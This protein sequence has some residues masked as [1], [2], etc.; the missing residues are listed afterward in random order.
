MALTASKLHGVIVAIVTPFTPKDEVDVPGLKKLVDYIVE[1][2]VHGIMTTG[3]NGEFPHLFHDERK[4][5]LEVIN[6][7]C[8]SKVP[9][10]ACVSACGTK[11]V[12][13]L[14]K[15]AKNVG[16]D[17]VILTPPYYFDLPPS[18]ILGHYSDLAKSVD[19]PIV[20]YNNPTYTRHNIT[21]SLAVSL[22]KI[23]G[24]VG[25]KQ[26]NANLS[27]AVEILRLV[28]KKISVLTG[29]DSQLFAAL[30]I[31]A[32][33]VFSTAACVYPKQMVDLYEA[34][35]SGK[36]AE[37]RKLHEKLQIVN[38]FFEYE[39]GYVTPCKEALTM[40]GLPAGPVR[41]P[42][43]PLTQ[44]ERAELKGALKAI[45]LKPN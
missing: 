23:D 32:R 24:V 33:G 21:P 43:P 3:G 45:G 29:I 4:K 6:D 16:A 41:K 22:S 44:Q 7:R 42:M 13:S 36:L 35:R 34:Y 30:C 10:I 25:L 38:K 15:H 19:I 27:E 37:A 8:P 9:V 31:G 11:E 1:N 20:A 5:V 39:P 12:I 2:G 26:S 28:G 40:L 14:S 18:A 17:A